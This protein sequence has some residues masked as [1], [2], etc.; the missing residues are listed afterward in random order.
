MVEIK[1]SIKFVQKIKIKKYSISEVSVK[2]YDTT[3]HVMT[4]YHTYY[5]QERDG[6]LNIYR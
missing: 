4:N 3:V 6:K 1:W 2:C 5:D